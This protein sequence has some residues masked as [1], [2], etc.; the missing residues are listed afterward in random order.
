[1]LSTLRVWFICGV[2]LRAAVV[3]GLR[4]SSC[5]YAA[6]GSTVHLSQPVRFLTYI[7][8]L[9]CHQTYGW[10]VFDVSMQFTE[11]TSASQALV[12]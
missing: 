11:A 6:E 5:R 1:M 9:R 8:V 7:T 2:F 4:W 10:L 3:S 12:A